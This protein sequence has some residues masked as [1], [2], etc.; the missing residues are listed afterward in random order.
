MNTERVAADKNTSSQVTT[1]EFKMS[2]VSASNEEEE[3]H[4]HT[5]QIKYTLKKSEKKRERKMNEWESMSFLAERM[6]V[7]IWAKRRIEKKNWSEKKR[8]KQTPRMER[9]ETCVAN[10]SE[11]TKIYCP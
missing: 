1:K 8:S 7:K 11:R 5:H 2:Y 6:R 4:K 10:K 9:D 3:S